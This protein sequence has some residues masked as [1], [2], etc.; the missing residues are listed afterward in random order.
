MRGPLQSAIE[1]PYWCALGIVEARDQARLKRVFH[2]EP[3]RLPCGGGPQAEGS[4]R[5]HPRPSIL[6]PRPASGRVV[7]AAGMEHSEAGFV[8]WP[9]L[10]NEP[11]GLTARGRVSELAGLITVP[12]V[13]QYG[14]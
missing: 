12:L 4:V 3:A 10:P 6:G 2:V 8:L 13:G 14:L 5:V 11:S 9:P 1:A 7:A